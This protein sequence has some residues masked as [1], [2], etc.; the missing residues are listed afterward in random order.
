MRV[1]VTLLRCLNMAFRPV[2]L[3]TPVGSGRCHCIHTSKPPAAD[4]A[5][6][7]EAR[8]VAAEAERQRQEAQSRERVLH[9]CE[10]WSLAA[11]AGEAPYLAR[12]GLSSP[13]GA[14]FAP[15][16]VPS[17]GQALAVCGRMV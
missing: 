9:A 6:A 5:H 11:E 3:S 4:D 12:K 10:L 14:R 2:F 13:Q 7:Q 15:G 8:R 16:G 17:A 1:L